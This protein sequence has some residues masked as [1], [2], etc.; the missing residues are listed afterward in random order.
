MTDL[1]LGL[2]RS[3]LAAGIAVGLVL[4]LR[5]PV[6]GLFGARVAYGL[7]TLAP[8]A[9]VAMLLPA[10]VVTL[11]AP[12]ISETVM[13]APA[14]PRTPIAI[15]H[16]IPIPDVSTILAVIWAAGALAA[17][18]W[19][20]WRQVQ[21]TRAVRAGHAGPAVVGVLRPRIVTPHDFA[22][23]YTER[24]QQ[25]VLAHERAH[26]ARQDPRINA[27]V[28]LARCA[29][30]FNP[31]VHLLVHYLRIDQELACDAQVVA[32]HPGARRAYAEAMLKTQLAARPLP[33]G[34]YWPSQSAHPLAERIGL[35]ARAA[36]GRRVRAAGAALLTLFAV[37]AGWA[38]W[39]ARPAEVVL[40]S[41][42]TQP[43][44]PPVAASPLANVARFDLSP[45]AAAIQPTH[46][47][48]VRTTDP[49]EPRA[50]DASFFRP[51]SMETEPAPQAAAGTTD[52]ASSEPPQRCPDDR[53][54]AAAGHGQLAAGLFGPGRKVHAVANWSSV[55]PGSAVRVVA[56]MSD[57]DGNLL[58]TD[59]TAFGSQSW[60]R[61]GCISRQDSRYK[62]FTSVAQHGARLTVTAGLDK[63]FRAIVSGSIELGSGETGT[64]TLPN[65]L[66]VTV[67]PYLRP[68]TPQES[69]DDRRAFVGILRVPAEA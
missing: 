12:E 8:F 30:W 28:A 16:S 40:V 44:S 57:P 10:R 68:E 1:L 13:A 33:L 11:S 61:L 59:L 19:L 35:L 64:I 41:T 23:R 60:Y 32:A 66:K 14:S 63:S 7:W 69:A 25:V 5:R 58:T 47:D 67:T 22:S 21:F 36:P 48:A 62:L 34:C 24:E 31:L 20:I 56:R 50:I 51:A 55:E 29:N 15:A 39:A 53:W 18:A 26:I 46:K 42:P 49:E 27:I 37:G 38:A 3:N 17:L 54:P 6:R 65:G 43:T 4:L 45:A 9:A 52:H 2:L